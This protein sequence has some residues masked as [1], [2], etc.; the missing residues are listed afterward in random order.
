MLISTDVSICFSYFCPNLHCFRT[1]EIAATLLGG[2]F[3][4]TLVLEF[5]DF[6]VCCGLK[7]FFPLAVRCDFKEFV[8]SICGFKVLVLLA[9]CCDFMVSRFSLSFAGR[10]L[11][12]LVVL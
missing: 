10:C 6:Y 7:V 3:V 1:P 11:L 9:F 8:C 2:F 12:Y 5:Q 4:R